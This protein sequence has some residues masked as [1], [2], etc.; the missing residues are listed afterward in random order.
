MTPGSALVEEPPRAPAT[1]PMQSHLERYPARCPALPSMP[2]AR[3]VLDRH[4]ACYPVVVPPASVGPA[5][6]Q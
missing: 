6:R 5:G 4:L 2:L 1:D 3:V